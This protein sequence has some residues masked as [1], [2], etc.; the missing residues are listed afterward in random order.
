MFDSLTKRLRDVRR[1]RAD[2]VIVELTQTRDIAKRHLEEVSAR[3]QEI[4]RNFGSDLGELRNLNEFDTAGSGNHQALATT[5]EQLR[6]AEVELERL[7]ALHSLLFAG[8][9]DPQKLLIGGRDLLYSQP[10]LQRLKEGLIDARLKASQLS[11]V[12]TLQNPKRKAAIATEREI[13]ERIIQETLSAIAS[14]QPRIELQVAQV[15]KLKQQAATL[16]DRLA[17]LAQ[18]TT[19]YSEIGSELRQRTEQVADA[20]KRLLE[21]HASRSAALST[22]LIAELGPPQVTENPIGPPMSTLTIGSMLAG[23]LVG[24]CAVFL[25]APRP[26]YSHGRRRWTDHLEDQNRRA[27]DRARLANTLRRRS[28]DPPQPPVGIDP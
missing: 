27:E 25:I 1:V 15:E 19:S 17:M 4:E 3:M 9:K 22:S 26:T 28:D 16:S 18:A 5:R 8:S 11:G 2:S 23:L 7:Q 14:M 13:R 12:Y 10:S 24:L 20:E 6:L 21:A